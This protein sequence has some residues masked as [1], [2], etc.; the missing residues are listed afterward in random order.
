MTSLPAIPPVIDL[1]PPPSEISALAQL[2]YE[3]DLGDKR[4]DETFYECLR[5]YERE[6]HPL[7]ELWPVLLSAVELNRPGIIKFLLSRGLPMNEMYINQ[8]IKTRSKEVFQAFFDCGW[9]VNTTWNNFRPPVL[10]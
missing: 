6:N 8:A 9:D 7:D 3:G 5:A 4:I 2:C 1:G 10:A